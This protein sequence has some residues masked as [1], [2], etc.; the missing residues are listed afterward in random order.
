MKKEH[1]KLP[2]DLYKNRR[3]LIKMAKNDLRNRFAGSYFGTIWA[4]IQP[5]VTILVYYFVFGVAMRGGSSAE[6]GTPF[7]L[8]LVAGIIPWLFFQEGLTNSTNSF[9]EYSYL[10]KKVVFDIDILPMVKLLSAAVVHCFFLLFVIILFGCYGRFPSVYYLE[11]I[12]YALCLFLLILAFAYITS[13]VVIF[14]RDLS[15]IVSIVL[16]VGVWLTPIMWEESMLSSYSWGPTALKILRLNPVYYI[17]HGYRNALIS[18]RWFFED[19]LWTLYFWVF[20]AASF[21]IGTW[22]FNRL[23]GHFADVL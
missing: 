3:L 2:K 9:L 21:A 8:Y 14:F 7:V 23:K 4:F 16:Q 13:S 1:F 20:L 11:L 5:I 12:Y 18:K 17:V 10:V 6:G 22:V 19:P 15:Q